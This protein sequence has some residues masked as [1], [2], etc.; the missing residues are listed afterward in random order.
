[1]NQSKTATARFNATTAGK[2]RPHRSTRPAPVWAR[3]TSNPGGINCGTTCSTSVAY[4]TTGATVTL[5][6]G[7]DHRLHLH[8]LERLRG[9]SDQSPAM[10]G[11]PD[12]W[13]SRHRQLHPAGAHRPQGG[14]RLGRQPR[15]YHRWHLLRR[16]LHRTL[17]PQHQVTLVAIPAIGF[18]FNGWSGCAAE[19]G[20]PQMCTV[21]MD[22]SRTATASFIR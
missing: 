14:Q 1:M 6:A 2:N 11:I 13:Q 4:F 9:Q 15:R 22:Q 10:H 17:Q 7:R 19:P 5:T 18:R 8:R 12:R 21:R 3:S 20:F 16:G